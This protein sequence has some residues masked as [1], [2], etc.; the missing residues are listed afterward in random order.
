MPIK[1]R[2]RLIADKACGTKLFRDD[3]REVIGLVRAGDS[4][5]ISDVIR[6]LVHEALVSRRKQSLGRDT[7]EDW[8]LRIHQQSV[9]EA[10]IPLRQELQQLTKLFE[11]PLHSVRGAN[12]S[13]D[14]KSGRMNVLLTEVLG[15]A[16]TAEMKAHLLLQNFLLGRGLSEE[17]IA[18][19]MAE[20]EEKSRQRTEEIVV[21]I[22]SSS[23]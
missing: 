6:Q 17:T 7:A 22:L 20:H 21:G 3:L 12:D 13:P 15:F 5:T 23:R 11:E 9:S 18:R 14:E 4:Q 16:M 2:P 10:L 1:G 8:F 19:L